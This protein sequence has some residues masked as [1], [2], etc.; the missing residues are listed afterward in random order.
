M[1]ICALAYKE[2]TL[3]IQF[4]FV[5][6]STEIIKNNFDIEIDRNPRMNFKPKA[7]YLNVIWS[8]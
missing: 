8:S 7:T 4:K 5:T 3:S 2:L 1:K 6:C